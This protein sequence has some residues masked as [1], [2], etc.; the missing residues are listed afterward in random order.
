M[1]VIHLGNQANVAANLVNGLNKYSDYEAEVHTIKRMHYEG[2]GAKVHDIN[3]VGML[4]KLMLKLTEADIIHIHASYVTV[5]VLRMENAILAGKPIVLHLHGS[6]IRNKFNEKRMRG[7]GAADR[8]IYSTP[9]LKESVEAY[10]LEHPPIY[11]ENPI[12][13]TIFKPIK[14]YCDERA[15][16]W[17]SKTRTLDNVKKCVKLAE[18]ELEKPVEVANRSEEWIPHNEMSTLYNKYEYVLNNAQTSARG[19][20][21]YTSLQMLATGGKVIS[22][23]D[24]E[25]KIYK[26][27]PEKHSLKN[28]T[29][30]LVKIYDEIV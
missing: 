14:P 8:V 25:V 13:K 18:K 19:S 5:Y 30:R 2:F 22:V 4:H 27:F 12:D 9:D 1:K 17:F 7:L 23:V 10:E 20:L 16:I 29:K 28:V 24:D 3:W 11:L 26:K 21:S 15:G 6:E